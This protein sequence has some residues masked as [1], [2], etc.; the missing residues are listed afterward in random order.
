MPSNEELLSQMSSKQNLSKLGVSKNNT[1]TFSMTKIR[2]TLQGFKNKANKSNNKYQQNLSKPL[3]ELIAALAVNKSNSLLNKKMGT[4]WTPEN[5]YNNIVRSKIQAAI[6]VPNKNN[7]NTIESLKRIDVIKL[8]I[9]VLGQRFG[10]VAPAPAPEPDTRRDSQ[11]KLNTAI[12]GLLNALSNEVI[13]NL[14][15]GLEEAAAAEAEVVAEAAAA[16][17]GAGEAEAEAEAAGAGE[18]AAA[19]AGAGEVIEAAG[20]E[21]IPELINKTY[22]NVMTS[23]INV[24]NPKNFNLKRFNR[25]KNILRGRNLNRINGLT[26]EKKRILRESVLGMTNNNFQVARSAFGQGIQQRRQR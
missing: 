17:A 18:A 7:A 26:E 25:F 11:E 9:K 23:F 20:E 13:A 12:T 10:A 3:G 8:I 6:R 4:G 16:G 14:P 19:A 21:A 24:A 22:N 5:G 2:E 1:A 15:T